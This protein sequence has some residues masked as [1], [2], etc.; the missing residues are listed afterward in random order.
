MQAFI[1]GMP[2]AELHV[3]L[4]GTLEPH[5]LLALAQRNRIELPLPAWKQW[6][7]RM[8]FTTCRRSSVSTAAPWTCCV[9]SRIFTT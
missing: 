9:W 5:M 4:E 3:H 8:V 1:N 6:S 7:P 2:K